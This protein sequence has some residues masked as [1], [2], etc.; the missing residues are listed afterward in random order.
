MI[1]W[2]LYQFFE[3]NLAIIAGSLPAIQPL[4]VFGLSLWMKCFGRC[5]RRVRANQHRKLSDEET[6]T[7][8]TIMVTRT[9]EMTK[10]ERV[11]GRAV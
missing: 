7:G 2:Y 4:L 9:V 3:V 1:K 5:S 6:Q 11:W 8:L 10:M